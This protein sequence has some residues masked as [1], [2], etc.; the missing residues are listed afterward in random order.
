M[1]KKQLYDQNRWKNQPRHHR[2]KPMAS[3]ICS[4]RPVGARW[5]NKQSASNIHTHTHTYTLF[6]HKIKICGKTLKSISIVN[7]NVVYSPSISFIA[8]M[9]SAGSLKLIKPNPLLLPVR[10]SRMT[11]ALRKEGYLLNV[12]V[13]NS[14]FTSLP[15]S[16]QNIRKSSSVQS[17][18]EWSSHTW[19][20]AVRTVYVQKNWENYIVNQSGV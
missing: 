2:R 6:Q 10:L 16:P 4:S 12:R 5:E 1:P 13:S 20:P 18:S 15:R 17:D 9:K 14:S 3:R 8:R 7:Q 19:P 11:L